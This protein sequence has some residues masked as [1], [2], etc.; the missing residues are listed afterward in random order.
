M[1]VCVI[2]AGWFGCH[3]AKKLIDDGFDVQVFEKE[4]DIFKNASGNNQNRLHQKKQFKFQKR[5]LSYLKKNII[6][7]LKKL[8]IIFIPYLNQNKPR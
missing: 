1:K 8:K 6:F 7:W 2:G 3:I 5:V 4:N